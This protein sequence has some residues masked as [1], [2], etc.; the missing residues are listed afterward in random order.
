MLIDFPRR[1][2][3]VFK[4]G[5]SPLGGGDLE[6]ISAALVHQTIE[7]PHRLCFC[8]GWFGNN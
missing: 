7:G 1:R 6:L 3:Q 8:L 5:C 2:P 4:I